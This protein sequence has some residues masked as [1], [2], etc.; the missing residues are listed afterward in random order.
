MNLHQH[1]PRVSERGQ[2]LVEYAL[3]I[4]L[5]AVVVT[6]TLALLGPTLANAFRGV[7]SGVSPSAA[8]ATSTPGPGST[9]TS[10]LN[11]ITSVSAVRTG[12]GHGNTVL[13]TIVVSVST[14]VT[15][16]DSQNAAPVQNIPC[17]GICLIP[18]GGAGPN[19]GTVTVTASAGGTRTASYPARL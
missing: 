3:I 14:L 9:P 5:V 17:N 12:H 18:L 13:V 16:T 6:A 2:G 1:H 4:A 8:V 11:V 7:A 19:A 15:V 10:Q